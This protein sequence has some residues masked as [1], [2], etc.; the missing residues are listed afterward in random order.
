MAFIIK[1]IRRSRRSVQP[2]ALAKF[3]WLLAPLLPLLWLFRFTVF[4]R[5]FC[6]DRGFFKSTR[7]PAFVISIGNLSVGGTGKTPATIFLAAALR[8]QGWRI[9]IVSKGYRREG[10]ASV[11]VSDGQHILA[12][13]VTAGDEP[14]LMARACSDVPVV[15][16]RDKTAAALVAFEK[17]APDIILVDDGFQHRRLQRDIDVVMVDARMPL[18]HLWWFPAWPMREPAAALR[19]ADFVILNTGGNDCEQVMKQ[20]R[21]YTTAKIFSGALRGLGWRELT[22]ASNI[23]PAEFVKDQPVLLVSGIAHPERFRESAEELGARVVDEIIFADHY[24]YREND[25]RAI[26]ATRKDSGARYILTTSKDAGKLELLPGAAA[27]PFLVL[28]TALEIETP[29][30]PAL[31]EAICH[32]R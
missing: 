23:L 19:R 29:F 31:V 4:A 18:S 15:V 1:S 7:L 14:L 32:K 26:E 17:F 27:T 3:R 20:C 30:L 10:T 12:D 6:Y 28:E 21:R 25:L 2:H 16:A 13:A 9:A 5:N 11:V 24:R 22:N 8:D